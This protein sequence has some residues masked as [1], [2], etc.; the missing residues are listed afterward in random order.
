MNESTVAQLK[1]T[2]LQVRLDC[3][4]IQRLVGSGHLG[5]SLSAVELLVYLY[6]YRM[7]IDPQRPWAEE[8][9][10]FILSKGHASLGYY[11]VLARR[12][13]FPVDEL[14]TYRQINSRLQG[15]TQMDSAPGIECSSGS[16]GQGLSFGLG[17]ALGYKKRGLPNLVYVMVGDGELQEGQIW[18]A[19]IL[20]S[21]LCLDNL[22]LIIDQNH[23]QLDDYVRNVVGDENYLERFRTFG[24]HAIGVDGHDFLG[25][26]RAF[27][28]ARP[29]WANVVI[30]DT[31]KGKG[32]SFMENQIAWHAK[33]LNAEEYEAALAEL[34]REEVSLC[35]N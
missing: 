15:H 19:I 28:E 12:G 10:I 6:F 34:K 32:I 31:V 4:N 14:K 26:D 24:F 23:L 8:R 25:I 5:G 22:I 17:M 33:K 1:K 29:G 18:E 16:L 13:F 27:R 30:A 20:Q 3:I 35:M 21:R 11:S 2:A 9:D 7:R